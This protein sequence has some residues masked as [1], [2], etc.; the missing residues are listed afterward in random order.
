MPT[1]SKLSRDYRLTA[2]MLQPDIQVV[3][4]HAPDVLHI[5][6]FAALQTGTQDRWQLYEALKSLARLRA[7]FSA[8][9][10]ELRENC[11]YECVID[12]LDALLPDESKME[13]SA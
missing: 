12:A 4:H 7:G 13:E 10:P 9:H 3:L 6:R 11:Y 1:T 8:Q 5:L 2:I